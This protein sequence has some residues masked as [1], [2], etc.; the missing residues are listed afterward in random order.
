MT[1]VIY[2]ARPSV[3]IQVQ[4]SAHTPD[5]IQQQAAIENALSM[6]LHFVRGDSPE[7]LRSATAKANRALS[8][9]KQAC[10]FEATTTLEG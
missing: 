6:A 7:G 10:A 8:L 5:L 1:N 3:A 9:L 2:L 4:P